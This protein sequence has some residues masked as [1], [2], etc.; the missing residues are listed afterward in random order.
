M[1]A[2]WRPSI[3]EPEI[4]LLLLHSHAFVF[5]WDLFALVWERE[6]DQPKDLTEVD[7]LVSYLASRDTIPNFS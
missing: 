1:I 6:L 3:V 7:A 4:N 5:L 2:A